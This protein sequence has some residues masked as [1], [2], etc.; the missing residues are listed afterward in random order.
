MT[1]PVLGRALAVVLALGLAAPAEARSLSDVLDGPDTCALAPSLTMPAEPVIAAPDEVLADMAHAGRHWRLETDRGPVHVWV[2]ENYDAATAATIVFVHGYHVDVDE[3]WTDYRLEQQF[4]LSGLNAM[5][6]APLSPREKRSPITW[7]SLD[8]LLRTVKAS[9]DVSM[10]AKRLV[11]VGH[12]GAYR[13]LAIWLANTRLDTVVLLDAVYGEYSFSPWVKS[14]PL[15]RLVNVV[16]ETDRFSDYM[17]RMLPSTVRVVGLP[18][19]GF[20]EARILYAKTTVGHY[21]LVTDGVALPLALRAIDVPSV[22]GARFDLPL[23]LPE[24]C[25][26]RPSA[27]R[28]AVQ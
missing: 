9:V 18:P 2:P 20:P 15:H 27:D 1:Y 6:I 11:A 10:P 26:Q 17:H 22:Q 3:A 7:P 14:S 5:F 23:G 24:R 19:E 13:T 21:P 4:A 28:L 16:F 25:D 12:S 8:A